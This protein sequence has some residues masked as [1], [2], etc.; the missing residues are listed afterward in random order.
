VCLPFWMF[1]CVAE[2]EEENLLRSLGVLHR[3][4]KP[5]PLGARCCDRLIFGDK[6][7]GVQGMGR[8]GK[9]FTVV[10]GEVQ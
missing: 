4:P 8:E 9:R 5:P 2:M 7:E 6:S 10:G 1:G 3:R